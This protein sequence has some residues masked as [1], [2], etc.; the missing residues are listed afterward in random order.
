MIRI[1]KPYKIMYASRGAIKTT[2]VPYTIFRVGCPYKSGDA[3][4]RTSV[5]VF[6]NTHIEGEKGDIITIKKIEGVNVKAPD[7][8]NYK[9]ETTLYVDPEDI[10][11]ERQTEEP[12]GFIDGWDTG[13][14]EMP[15]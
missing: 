11:I 8:G 6:V 5:S 7:K 4:V 13:T 9:H 12:Q 3:W 1:D 10:E 14:D 15:F 2:G